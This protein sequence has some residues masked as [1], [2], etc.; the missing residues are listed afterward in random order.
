MVEADLDLDVERDQLL[1]L[2]KDHEA[3]WVWDNR[4]RLVAE[5][6]FLDTF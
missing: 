2:M 3:E 4:R 1:K 6:I 5:R